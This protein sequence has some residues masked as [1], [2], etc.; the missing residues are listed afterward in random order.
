LIERG[1]PREGAVLTIPEA[2]EASLMATIES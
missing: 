1:L 2:G